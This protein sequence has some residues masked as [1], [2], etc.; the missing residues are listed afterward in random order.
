MPTPAEPLVVGVDL[1]TSFCKA[2]A[3][4][5]A[6]RQV[7]L[8]AT[9]TPWRR[10]GSL[11]YLEAA[12]LEQRA[13]TAIA[14]ALASASE[15]PVAALGVTSMGESGVLLDE[16]GEAVAPV[17]AWFDETAEA[18]RAELEQLVGAAAFAERTGVPL[19]VTRSAVK[20]AWLRRNVSGSEQGVRWL[21]LA[22]WLVHRL[23]ART[24]TEASLGARTGLLELRSGD[25][26]DQVWQW[27]RAPAGLLASPEAAG[28]DLG[29]AAETGPLQGSALVVAGHDHQAAAHGAGA[30]SN[31][32]IVVSTGT[33]ITVV[34][35]RETMTTEELRSALTQ[36]LMIGPDLHRRGFSMQGGFMG[37]QQLDRLASRL[38]LERE[39]D[40][41]RTCDGLAAA[42]LARGLADGEHTA[43]PQTLD[44]AVVAAWAEAMRGAWRTVAEIVSHTGELNGDERYIV[45]GGWTRSL[46][47]RAAA[48]C[49]RLG[50]VEFSDAREP[51]AL[52]AADLARR[53]ARVR[54]R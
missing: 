30:R 1:G 36:G 12:D 17:L 41:Y 21:S 13:R 28:L 24:T 26:Y 47:F 42:R 31:R 34:R 27:A 45:C 32:D 3:V 39:T 15:A 20:Y 38:G 7:G 54:G 52:G 18:E 22:E 4:D 9:A 46:A 6:G 25:P 35:R 5:A 53:A 19:D 48:A 37:G 33:T 50:H 40:L 2:V 10:R 8:G 11:T 51:G 23:G 16:H 14:S 43:M 44:P 29:K 49:S